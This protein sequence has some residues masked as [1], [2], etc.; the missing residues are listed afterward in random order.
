MVWIILILKN[1]KENQAEMMFKEL[2]PDSQF[3]ILSKFNEEGRGKLYSLVEGHFNSLQDGNKAVRGL[4]QD[5]AETFLRGTIKQQIGIKD[6][7]KL[8]DVVEHFIK[9]QSEKLVRANS[10]NL[11]R[12]VREDIPLYYLNKRLPLGRELSRSEVEET[13]RGAFYGKYTPDELKLKQSFL[14]EFVKEEADTIMRRQGMIN[15]KKNEKLLKEYEKKS[16]L[17]AKK[18]LFLKLLLFHLV[19]LFQNKTILISLERK[20]FKW[21]KKVALAKKESADAFEKRLKAAQPS[22]DV[23]KRIDELT[24]ELDSLYSLTPETEDWGEI[25]KLATSEDDL[26]L[27]HMDLSYEEF[28]KLETYADNDDLQAFYDTYSTRMDRLARAEVSAGRI[29]KR[30]SRHITRTL[31]PSHV[32]RGSFKSYAEGL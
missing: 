14:D 32:H 17:L 13:I 24:E 3:D 30:T 5:T 18:Q 7:D 21:R 29:G 8:E 22:E 15:V 26:V 12:E 1:L 31:H 27:K 11:F 19:I 20:F 16:K 25:M 9:E 4:S 10:H 23:V 28:R 6:A 2:G